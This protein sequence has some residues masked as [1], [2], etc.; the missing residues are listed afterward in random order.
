M[1]ME[2]KFVTGSPVAARTEGLALG[3]FD[4]LDFGKFPTAR[5]LKAEAARLRFKGGAG[6]SFFSFNLAGRPA[7]HVLVVGLGKRSAFGPGALRGA[8]ALAARRF[9]ERCLE[10]A[11]LAFPLGEETGPARWAAAQALVEGATL[12]N[13]R[14]S[15]YKTE[16]PPPPKGLGLLQIAVAKRDHDLDEGGRLGE[17]IAQATLFARSL[18]T[19]PANVLTPERMAEEAR[20]VAKEGGLE[21]KILGPAECA[22]LGMG[23]FLAVARGSRHEPRFIHLKYR[24]KGAKYHLAL[25]GKGLTFDSG[26]ISIKPADGMGAMKSDMSGSAAVLGAMKAVGAL[27]PK[28]AVDAVMAMCE[29]MP[30][31]DAYRPGDVLTSMSGKTIEVL[32][33]DAEGRL[34]L[35]DALTYVQREKADAVID[36]ATLTGAC[37]VAL[38]PDF[39]GAMGNDQTLMDEVLAAARE[40]GDEL[41]QLPLPAAYNKYIKS[42]VAD[43]ANMSRIRWGGALT[44][45][46][47]LQNFVQNG[48][49]WVHLD[50]AG[51][52]LRDDD[53]ADAHKGEGSGVG[54]RTLVRFVLG[55]QE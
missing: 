47:F 27:K 11:T 4:D 34:T 39:S 12:G 51:P 6:E 48:T 42:D 21:I 22:K 53:G 38:G 9:R 10:S 13:A 43:V 25:V 40:S 18:V 30:D 41:W 2:W 15:R 29:N 49:P 23:A 19:E 8:A 33:T 28:V 44:A 32:N 17:V 3:V 14:F 35:A 7:K 36:L 1:T 5:A 54:V 26:G 31:G 24:P 52:A 50:I 55:K 45:G 46:L 16:D 20:A 37:V